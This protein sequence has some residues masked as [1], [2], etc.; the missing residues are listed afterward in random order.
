[1]GDHAVSPESL[2]S[3]LKQTLQPKGNSV[4]SSPSN[5]KDSSPSKKQKPKDELDDLKSLIRATQKPK[6]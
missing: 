2:K 3:T 4:V 6:E 5:P 1:M